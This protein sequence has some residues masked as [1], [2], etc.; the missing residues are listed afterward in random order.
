MKKL[1]LFICD[2]IAFL[3]I[4]FITLNIQIFAL[5]INSYITYFKIILPFFLVS[6]FFMWL[7]FIY[8]L[9]ILRRKRFKYGVF[10][11][12]YFVSVFFSGLLYYLIVRL[13]PYLPTLVSWPMI[14]ILKT[15]FFILVLAIR[16]FFR[17]ILKTNVMIFGNS[18][19]INELIK[20]FENSIGY[21]ICEIH[22]SMEGLKKFP[23]SKKLLVIVSHDLFIKHPKSWPVL[24]EKFV[25]KGIPVDT[26]FHTFKAIMH[27]AS[28]ENIKNSKWL[29]RSIAFRNQEYF[30]IRYVKRILDI[31]LAL[32]MLLLLLPLIIFVSLVIRIVDRE[33]VFFTQYRSGVLNRTIKLYKFRTIKKKNQESENEEYTHTGRLLRRFRIDEIPQLINIIKGDISFIGPRPLW[34]KDQKFW[35]EHIPNHSVRTVIKPGLT[36]WAQ[37]NFKAPRVYMKYKSNEVT[38][39]DIMNEALTRF[40]YDIWYLQNCSLLLDIDIFFRTIVRIF[41]KD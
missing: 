34:I 4:L 38:K 19:T 10:I 41:V 26:D 17:H 35:D 8:D 12:I 15:I 3:L 13:I 39:E 28:F 37:V 23:K 25:F 30:Y 31:T 40:S 21:K 29:M 22:D 1:Y 14:V 7:F 27:R 33:E 36:G 20:E 2:F 16:I 11:F 32:I 9:S 6:T 24:I 5:N 18:P